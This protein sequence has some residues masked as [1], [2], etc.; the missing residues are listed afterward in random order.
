MPLPSIS[1]QRS[2]TGVAVAEG[3][4]VAVLT[5]VLVGVTVLV[6]VS[7]AGIAGYHCQRLQVGMSTKMIS[8]SRR[9][10]SPSWSRS[11]FAL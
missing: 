4:L 3:V 5:A 7:V 10:M 11:Y 1:A 9:S 8:T 6:G 2:A